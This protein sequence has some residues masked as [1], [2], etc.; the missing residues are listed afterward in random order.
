MTLEE[1]CKNLPEKRL[2]ELAIKLAK[3]TLTIWDKYSEKKS[4]SYRDSIV[5]LKHKVDKNILKDTVSELEVFFKSKIFTE[6]LLNLQ[7]QFDDPI[8]ALQD[9][10]WELPNEVEK[11]FFCI[12]NLLNAVNEIS[13]TVTFE[14]TLHI[15]INQ[16]IEAL[17]ISGTLKEDE[18]KEILE[19][20]KTNNDI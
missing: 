1:F 18:I 11:A 7:S 6:K 2:I 13:R 4:L 20:A 9:M 8:I 15:S 17:E 16:A 10:D 12:Y 3:L 14:S 5:G 19:D